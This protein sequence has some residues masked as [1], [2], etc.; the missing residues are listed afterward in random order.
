MAEVLAVG[1]AEETVWELAEDSAASP[2]AEALLRALEGAARR[3]KHQLAD[4]LNGLVQSDPYI[5]PVHRVAVV[6]VDARLVKGCCRRRPALPV[7]HHPH[8]L[9]RRCR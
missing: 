3:H 5:G 2:E 4:F 9:Q 8:H 6:G 1:D 7:H